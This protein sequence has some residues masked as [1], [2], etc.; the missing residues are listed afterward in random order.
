MRFYRSFI[1]AICAF[2][3]ILASCASSSEYQLKQLVGK[4]I[5][6]PNPP[7]GYKDGAVFCSSAGELLADKPYTII[8]VFDKIDCNSCAVEKIPIYFDQLSETFPEVAL[9]FVV[10]M[11]LGVQSETLSRLTPGVVCMYDQNFEF[12]KSNYIP[13]DERLKTWLVDAEGTI[14]LAGDPI[15]NNELTEL[16]KSIIDSYLSLL[17]MDESL[18]ENIRNAGQG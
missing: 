14:I 16:Y 8:R 10:P 2:A 4:R 11:S 6:F 17:D 18:S 1:P 15:G 7:V 5:V 3:C 9:I 13:K 12:T